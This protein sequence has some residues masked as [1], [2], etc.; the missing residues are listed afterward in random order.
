MSDLNRAVENIENAE[1][2]DQISD[3]DIEKV[4]EEAAN[5]DLEAETAEKLR[6]VFSAENEDSTPEPEDESENESEDE[7]EESAEDE[8]STPEITDET[9]AKKEN[10]VKDE[11]PAENPPLSDALYRAAIHRGWTEKEVDDFYD[12]NPTLCVQTLS[13]IHESVNRSSKEFAALGRAQKMQPQP[14]QQ[15]EKT[16]LQ[17]ETTTESLDI[18]K[19][20]KEYPD[21]PIVD[22]IEVMQ[23]NNMALQGKVDELAQQ[24]YAP[25]Q[26]QMSQT[27][28]RE[29][30]LIQQQIEG[31]FASE[32]AQAYGDFYGSLPKDAKDWDSLTPGQKA[33][34]WAVI[35]MMDQIVTGAASLGQTMDIVDGMRRAHLSVSEP[36]REKVIRDKIVKQV[37][38]RSKSLSLKPSNAAKSSGN[39]KDGDD[40]VEITRQRLAKLNW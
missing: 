4:V 15:A 34:R 3:E 39:A 5:I 22:M 30:Q 7:S 35:E 36:L 24:Q 37:K 12:A 18:A 17:S 23:K 1:S 28:L 13:K 27:Q 6:S 21:D 2:D 40:L 29:Q 19:L 10:E 9:E 8:G 38:K 26:Q 20:R 16:T 33:N 32:E 31:F 25:V 14:A 11:K